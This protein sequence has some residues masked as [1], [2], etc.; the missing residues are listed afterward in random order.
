MLG[1]AARADPPPATYVGGKV[2]APCH[3]TETKRWQGSHHD[4]AM[5]RANASTVRGNFAGTTFAKDGVTTI[6]TTR[7]GRYHVR[8]DGPDGKLHDYQLPYTFGVEP[9]QQYLVELPGGRYQALGVAWDTRPAAAGGQRWFHVYGD[10]KID[11]KDQLHWTGAQ[12]NWNYMCA[13]CHSTSLVKGH[14]AKDD[15][16]QTTWTDIDVSCEAC[17][18]PGSRHVAWAERKGAD[19]DPTRGLVVRLGDASGGA[20]QFVPG[21]PIARRTKPLASRVEVETCGRCHARRAQVWGEYHHGDALAQTHLVALL[22]PDLYHPDGQISGEVYEYGSFLQSRMYEAGVTCSDCHDPHSGRLRASGNAV[23]ARCHASATYDTPKH[24]FHEAGTPAAECVSC[25]MSER[26]YMVVDGRRDHSFRVP[27]PDLSEKL[28]TPNAC[29]DCHRDKIAAWAAAAVAKWYGPGRR[30]GWHWGEALDAGRRDRADAETQL[31]RAIW[32]SA[33]PGI[34][35]ATAVSLLAPRLSPRSL[36]ALQ[37]AVGDGDPIVRRAATDALAS[38]PPRERAALGMPLLRDPV[39]TVRLEALGS[40]VELPRDSLTG[41]Q[42]SLLDGAVAEYRQAQAFNADRAEAHA[43]L[44]VL[45]RRLGNTEAAATAFETAIR[46]QPWFVP[47]YLY[48]ADLRRDQGREADAEA[49]LRKAVAAEPT[50]ADAHHALGLALVRQKRSGEALAALAKAAGLAPDVPRY[51]YVHAVALH[52][53]GDVAGA[54]VALTKAHE[55][56]PGSRE[57]VVALAEYEAQAGNRDAARRWVRTLV[58]LAPD[59]PA[60]R[61]LSE[62]LEAR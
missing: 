2:C 50:S 30:Q 19:A 55:R 46:L 24:H 52:D 26:L 25:H 58:Q 16:Y 38:L 56:A 7:D 21:Q 51:A 36:P 4:L 13:E 17:H 53:G 35:R 12:Q 47:A 27:R 14:Q 44:G 34:A 20:W 62:V 18:G 48:L 42:Q 49:T 45:E 28:G 1:S 15:R 33:V 23:C 57:I 32:D 10:E 41:E 60:A 3:E 5:Q 8:T 29:T 31:V 54:I 43:N 40:L 37:R 6:F 39:R 61:R 22:E 11:H 59:D 9:L